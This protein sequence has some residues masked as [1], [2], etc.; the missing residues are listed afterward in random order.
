MRVSA[1]E[2]FG[3]ISPAWSWLWGFAE[4]TFFFVVPDVLFTLVMLDSPKRGWRHFGMAIA[5]ALVAGALMYTWAASSPAHARA[6]VAAVPFLG[7]KIITPTEAKWNADGTP[8]LFTNPLGGVPYKVYAVLAPAHVSLPVFAL[9]SLP[10]RVERMLLSMI[11]FVPLS[12]WVQRG[13]ET[14]RALGLRVHA[15]FWILV[16]AIYWSVNYS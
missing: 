11:V 14:R 12:L 13:G 16:Y 1:S 4:A 10:L 2:R 5:G 6:A 9:I 15:A 7:E 3:T 8:G